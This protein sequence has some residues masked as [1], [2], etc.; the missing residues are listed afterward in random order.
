V[1]PAR[2]GQH[3]IEL[4]GGGG[5][6][7]DDE[8]EPAKPNESICALCDDGGDLL[9]CDGVCMRSFHRRCVGLSKSA[10]LEI[11]VRACLRPYPLL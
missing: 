1:T 2:V 11:K 10:Y 6:G 7:S 4:P 3:R 8:G 5:Q 9:M